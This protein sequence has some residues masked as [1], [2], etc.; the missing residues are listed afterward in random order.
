MVRAAAANRP[1]IYCS[2]EWHLRDN[3]RAGLIHTLAL[4]LTDSGR[5]EFFVSQ[6]H[7]AEYFGWN[8]K[9]VKAA[10]AALRESGLFVLLRS[11]KGGAG[12]GNFAS[13]YRVLSHSQLSK[14]AHPCREAGMGPKTGS[15]VSSTSSPENG[16]DPKIP[17]HGA[18]VR[19]NIGPKT[20]SLVSD[21]SPKESTSSDA[22]APV[23]QS[24]ASPTSKAKFSYFP[25]NFAPSDDNRAL[26]SKLGVNLR[27]S[28]QAFTDYCL[29]TGTR[30][31]DWHRALNT[32]LRNDSKWD[33]GKPKRQ[34][35][36]GSALDNLRALEEKYK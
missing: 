9:T 20:G 10:F 4:H 33:R 8:L 27:D 21:E 16:P 15:L 26:A 3:P 2:A 17:A 25:S 28:V 19:Q 14:T 32:W 5:A 13:V 1:R 7:V 22:D 23:N 18:G 11:G 31:V 34:Q 36:T 12:Q 30:R 35:V 6:P 29:S 24:S